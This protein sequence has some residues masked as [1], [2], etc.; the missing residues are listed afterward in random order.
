MNITD[1]E[2]QIFSRQLILNE[3]KEKNFNKLQKKHI[4]IIGMGG[5]GC[6]LSQ[7]L[8]ASGIK[9]LTIID[10]DKIDITN[11]NRQI[12][13]SFNDIGK[14]K[15]E[16][17]KIKL[18]KINPNCSIHSIS[19][20]ITKLN[21]NTYI[22]EPS[23]IIDSTDNWVSM[24]IINEFCVKNSIPLISSSVI[25]F[26]GQVMFFKNDKSNHLCLNCIYPITN[27]PDLPR[28][29]TVGISSICAG[30]AGLITAQ[31]TINTLLNTKDETNILTLIDTSDLN[32][33]N[34]KIKNNINCVLNN[35]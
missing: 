29:E 2:L 21:I 19:K 10:H 32:I 28:C 12:L 22:K 15:A 33:S 30:I 11:L 6:P 16:I 18:S 26:D 4:I 35:S 5:I 27:E 14:N 25:G 17:A 13:F 23:I 7:Y 3:F 9:K 31:K 1:Q 34:I 24:N 20:K 8:I